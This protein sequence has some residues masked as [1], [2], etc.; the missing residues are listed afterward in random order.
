MPNPKD[1]NSALYYV[2][3]VGDYTHWLIAENDHTVEE[4]VAELPAITAEAT[5]AFHRSLLSQLHMDILVHGNLYKEDALKLTDLIQSTLKPRVLPPTQWPILR[6]FILPP[7][8]NYLYEKTLEDPENVNH[9]IETWLYVG[10]KSD[11]AVR[12]KIL[13]LDQMV[14][15]PAFDQLRTKEQLGYVVFSGVRATA[16]TFGFRF[17]IQS[18]KSTRYLDA[19]IVFI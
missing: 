3:Q 1:V 17:I 12:A 19:R 9:C 5:A 11:R 6:S 14:H 7:G 4:L 8:S 10:D 13:L 2:V 16:T 18:E 15:E